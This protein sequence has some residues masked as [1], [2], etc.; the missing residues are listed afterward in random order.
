MAF[1]TH[2][3]K[4]TW[5]SVA[6][7]GGVLLLFFAAAMVHAQGTADISQLQLERVDDGIQVSAQVLFE[8][9][10]AVEDALLKSI[11]LYFVLQADVF[12]E[13]WYWYDKKVAAVERRM[14]LAYQPLTR[15][16]RLNVSSGAGREGDVG[17]ALN[18][19]FD[20]LAQ[21]LAVI[22]RVSRW[23]I[24]EAADLDGSVKYRMELR[25][26]LDLSQLPRPFQIGAVGQ[27][28]WDIAATLNAPLVAD[29]QK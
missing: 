9:P 27:S 28:D 17:L 10:P 2:C 24:A 21:A 5:H 3:C 11:P 8:L 4:N 20:T 12:R 16:W 18:Q 7:L 6:R 23:K 13:R 25:F 14:R 1:I 26:R 29:P 22:K 15:H 19:S